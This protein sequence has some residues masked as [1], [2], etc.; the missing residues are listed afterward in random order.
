ME[1]LQGV[2]PIIRIAQKNEILLAKGNVSER[3]SSLEEAMN[4]RFYGT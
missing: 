3:G 4:Y 2:L 1:G